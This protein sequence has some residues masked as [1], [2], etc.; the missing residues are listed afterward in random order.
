[1]ANSVQ[2]PEILVDD[3]LNVGADVNAAVA[4]DGSL[5]FIGFTCR[6]MAGT[7]AAA[8]FKIVHSALGTGTIVLAT[9]EL[10][11]NESR[12]DWMYP[13]IPCPNGISIDWISGAID[14]HIFYDYVS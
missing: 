4:A 14:I 2:L 9:V 11:A 1:M 5:R 13:G 10:N 7:P 6:E 8:A 12:S 3:N